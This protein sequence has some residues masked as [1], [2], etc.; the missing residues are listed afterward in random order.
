M[1]IIENEKK[2]NHLIYKNKNRRFILEYLKLHP[3]V[4][5][6]ETDPVVLEFDHIKNKKKIISDMVTNHSLDKIKEELLKC[7]VRC[8]NCHRRKTAKDYNWYKYDLI[9]NNGDGL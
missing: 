2:E 9:P 4:D 7:E 3:G 6:G 5:C 8:A 1:R